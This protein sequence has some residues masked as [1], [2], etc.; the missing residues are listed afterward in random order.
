M[1]AHPRDPLTVWA[2]P[3]NGAE[4]GRF[5]PGGEAAVWRTHDGGETWL[6]GDTGLPRKDAYLTVL[7]EAMARDALDPVGVYFGTSTGQLYGSAD[8]GSSWAPIVTTLPPIWS[9][10]AI[11]V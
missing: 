11:V 5:M 7:R 4:Q 3:L 9:V 6:R 8:G 2:I 10:E 1:V